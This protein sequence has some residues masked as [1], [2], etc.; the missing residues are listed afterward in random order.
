MASN[1]EHDSASDILSGP[2]PASIKANVINFYDTD[3][4]ACK[5]RFAMTIDNV[6]TQKECEDLLKLFR[7]PDNNWPLADVRTDD[8]SYKVDPDFRFSGRISYTSQPLADRLFARIRPLLRD[9][10]DLKASEITRWNPIKQQW[11][12]SRLRDE[13]HFLKY[14]PGQYYKPHCDLQSID[15]DM[16][17]SFFSVILYLNGG[18]D[19]NDVVEGGATRFANDFE[20]PGAGKLDINPKA[21]RLLIYQQRFLY[22][23]GV[24]VTKG[25][26]Y[27]MRGSLM[28]AQTR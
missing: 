3:V 7:P 19:G 25:T 15:R 14:G 16:H 2:A 8:G 23:E 13:L 28:Y 21:G 5:G 11:R 18:C 12:I 9:I 27:V 10:V 24:E 4:D 20:N 17:E 22:H 6:L 1:A 26:K